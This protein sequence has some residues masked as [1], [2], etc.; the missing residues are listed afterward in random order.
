MGLQSEIYMHPLKLRGHGGLASDSGLKNSVDKRP[1]LTSYSTS[2][3][4]TDVQ[5]F[6]CTPLYLLG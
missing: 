3:A 6:L 2:E 1:M 5:E 4:V